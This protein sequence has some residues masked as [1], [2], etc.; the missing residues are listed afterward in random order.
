MK[1]IMDCNEKDISKQL[2]KRN[3]PEK[4]SRYMDLAIDSSIIENCQ[5]FGRKK[6]D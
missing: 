2:M 1:Y 3:Y 6:N 4:R 5:F